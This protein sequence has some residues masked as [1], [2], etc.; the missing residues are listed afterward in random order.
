MGYDPTLTQIKSLPLGHLSYESVNAIS[1][2]RLFTLSSRSGG[3]SLV[4]GTTMPGTQHNVL[5]AA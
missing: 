4:L 1:V 5:I 2:L 3:E